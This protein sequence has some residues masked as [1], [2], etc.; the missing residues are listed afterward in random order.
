MRT[1]FPDTLTT[2][3]IYL[4]DTLLPVG[5]R[6]IKQQLPSGQRLEIQLPAG[7]EVAVRKTSGAIDRANTICY[8]CECFGEKG[9]CE[10]ALYNVQGGQLGF[11]Q[12]SCDAE[13]IGW[14]CDE[15]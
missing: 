12:G 7:V 4:G 15:D 1:A 6:F 5:T 2:E 11:L 14:Y 3:Q 9:T 10:V 13:V 8:A